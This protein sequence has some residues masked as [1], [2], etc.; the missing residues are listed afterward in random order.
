M[1]KM[2]VNAPSGEQQIIEV[3]RGG[4]Y[5]D[6]SLVIWDERK[7]GAING[8]VDIVPGQMV[9]DCNNIIKLDTVLPEHQ[10]WLD[11][12]PKPEPDTDYAKMTL[13]QLIDLLKVKGL[14]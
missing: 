1:A 13:K 2:I 4:E 14:I 3:G 8:S 9:R 7:D 12:K 5:F 11:A 10:K 6:M